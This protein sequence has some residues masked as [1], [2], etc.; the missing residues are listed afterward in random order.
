MPSLMD[1][2]GQAC[3]LLFPGNSWS[4]L[5]RISESPNKRVFPN[6][7]VNVKYAAAKLTLKLVGL[8]A[9]LFHSIHGL[10]FLK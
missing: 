10:S 5:S 7:K 2:A 6:N 3:F 9:F 4:E 8:N 1:A